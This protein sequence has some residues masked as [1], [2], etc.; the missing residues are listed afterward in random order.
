MDAA[1][2]DL[3]YEAGAIPD[4]WSSVLQQ[5]AIIAGA[6]GAVL[7]AIRQSAVRW[8]SSPGLFEL[9]T[10]YF[11]TGQGAND[12]RTSRLLSSNHPGFLREIDVF[13]RNEIEDE[14]I[15]R[16]FFRPRGFGW[17]VATAIPSPSGDMLIV[18]VER[19]TSQGPADRKVVTALDQLRP[20]LA[21]SAL[22]AARLDL[23]R[24][25]SAVMALEIVGLPAAIL[26]DFGRVV[27]VNDLFAALVP[28]VAQ[29]RFSRMTLTDERADGLLAKAVG[30]TANGA[31]RSIPI[32]AREKHPPMILHVVPVRGSAHDIFTHAAAIAVVTPVVKKDVPTAEVVQALYDL[33][34]A[35][36]RVARAIG[37]GKTAVEIAADDR[38]TDRH[39][40]QAAQGGSGKD[41]D[42]PPG[43]P[44][45]PA[46]RRCLDDEKAG[47]RLKTMLIDLLGQDYATA[48]EQIY[49][50][51]T[52]PGLWPDTLQAIADVF[53]RFRCDPHLSQ[54]S[55]EASGTIVSPSMAP[56]QAAYQSRMVA[57]R[58]PHVAL[59]RARLFPLF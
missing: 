41:G 26:D 2:V 45:R 15:L 16:D 29:D 3:I 20:H 8:L 18:H 47:R 17:G 49:A 43:G 11:S 39:S 46:E 1:F 12:G 24:A 32:R 22:L 40:S 21:R 38:R 13:R 53:R 48:I 33:T 25:R 23:M 9:A 35:E 14:P 55:T 54:E 4:C 28:E 10:E 56:A 19:A 5:L 7:F 42:A 6:Q 31:G 51:A 30:Q 52:S 59:G 34:P 50:A 44:P 27:A 58:C 57:R 37:G 36:S